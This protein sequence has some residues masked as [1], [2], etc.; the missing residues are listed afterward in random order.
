M[1]MYPEESPD[2]KVFKMHSMDTLNHEFEL[3]F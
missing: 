3:F 1:H 2:K